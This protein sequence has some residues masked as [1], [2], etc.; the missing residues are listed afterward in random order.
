MSCPQVR[1]G[2]KVQQEIDPT[3]HTPTPRT[4]RQRHDN[5]QLH[6]LPLPLPPQR[7]PRHG[8]KRPIASHPT[9]KRRF[10]TFEVEQRK[11]A[12]CVRGRKRGFPGCHWPVYAI[13]ARCPCSARSQW[14]GNSAYT[15]RLA[16][17]GVPRWLLTGAIDRLSLF[18][19]AVNGEIARGVLRECFLRSPE[20]GVDPRSTICRVRVGAPG[21]LEGG[22][23]PTL[24]VLMRKYRCDSESG[25]KRCFGME[26]GCGQFVSTLNLRPG[27]RTVF[28]HDAQNR[29]KETHSKPTISK[30]PS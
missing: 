11:R 3:L 27:V 7:T 22:S 25:S 15:S 26:T 29:K 8:P 18:F 14:L 24:G 16:A 6:T 12:W 9:T 20:F 2:E 13:S 30:F 28:T 19:V 4:N 21:T 23:V 17:R 1:P 10:Q 5:I